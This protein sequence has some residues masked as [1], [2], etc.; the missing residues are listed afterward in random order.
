VVIS[1]IDLNEDVGGGP[2]ES[3]ESISPFASKRR[4]GLNTWGLVLG[5]LAF[6]AIAI[7][8]YVLY[9]LLGNP[10]Q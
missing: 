10:P 8:G 1:G 3:F 2:P 4:T 7:V 5:I 9:R 6:L